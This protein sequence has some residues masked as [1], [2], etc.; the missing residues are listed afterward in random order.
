MAP[1]L[2]YFEG[3]KKRKSSCWQNHVILLLWWPFAYMLSWQNPCHSFTSIA[4]WVMLYLGI[5]MLPLLTFGPYLGGEL[6]PRALFL[7][8]DPK[9][10]SQGFALSKFALRF[11]CIPVFHSIDLWVMLSWQSLL[12]SSIGLWVVLRWQTLSSCPFSFSRT[13]SAL[14]GLALSNFRSF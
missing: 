5:I 14:L 3:K 4:L 8:V 7:S 1:K 6:C 2:P 12:Y 13:K 9:T 11:F 10:H